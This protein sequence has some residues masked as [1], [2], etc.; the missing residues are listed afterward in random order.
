M[1]DLLKYLF[2]SSHESFEKICNL[3]FACIVAHIAVSIQTMMLKL[4]IAIA[5]VA[6]ICAVDHATIDVYA[7]EP[8]PSFG[9]YSTSNTSTSTN[10][11]VA[12]PP[13]QLDNV[14]YEQPDAF[15]AINGCSIGN[16]IVG[17]GYDTNGVENG[18]NTIPPDPS[19]AAGRERL[20]AVVNA[21]IEVR[22]K[23]GSLTYRDSLKDFFSI[24]GTSQ[25][26]NR[27]FDPKV[28]YDEHAQRFVVVGLERNDGTLVSRILLAVSKN[29]FPAAANDWY[30]IAINSAV[31]IGGVNSWADY[32]G[33][34]VDEEAVYITANM[35]GFSSG[36]FQGTRLWIVNKGVSGGF[37]GGRSA[38]FAT[39][40]PYQNFGT[41]TTTMPAQVHGSGGAGI[42]IGTFLVSIVLFTDGSMN[43]QIITVQN[44]LGAATFTFNTV[45]LGQVT[46]VSGIP[47]SPQLGSTQLIEANDYRTLDAV[48]RNNKLW[49]TLTVVPLASDIN[50]NQATAHW[51]R[52]NTSTFT[53]EAQ[54]NLGGEAISAQASTMFPAVAVNNQGQVA[55]G[56]AAS[57][58][59]IYAGAYGSIF[60]GN[61]EHPFTVK[62]GVDYYVRTLGGPRN[63]WGDYT[64]ISVD[65]TDGSFW[66]FN[67]FADV[68]GAVDSFGGSG[69]WG[70]AWARVFCVR[71]I[72][73]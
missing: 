32:P 28:V 42:S 25:A 33:F 73:A 39:Y 15:N 4:F 21:M 13:V 40:N 46:Q 72:G 68:R 30:M 5:L 22:T 43:V 11:N 53:L 37:Y 47:D 61:V 58:P 67:Q 38:T 24:L 29:E 54:G 3:S 8:F 62:S 57:S 35:F 27:Y 7:T 51:V 66:I 19:G 65:P 64:G 16:F 9:I 45:A 41:A 69:R 55:F 63:R 34:E 36:T 23:A 59:T 12:S 49:L 44:P 50:A 31:S 20:V 71:S 2:E 56:Y 26:N 1:I 48:W 10:G 6:P 14:T 52:I 60:L 18:F 70:T 17:F